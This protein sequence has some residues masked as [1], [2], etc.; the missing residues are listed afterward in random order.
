M[1]N[2]EM[3]SYSLAEMKDK[4]IGE[5]GTLDRDKYESELRIDILGRTIKKS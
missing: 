4:Y 2:K 3:K 1:K 5:I